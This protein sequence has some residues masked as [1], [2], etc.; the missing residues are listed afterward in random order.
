MKTALIL[1]AISG[2]YLLACSFEYPD[3]AFERCIDQNSHWV[4]TDTHVN[5][6][7]KK[8]EAITGFKSTF[9]TF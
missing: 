9:N 2:L 5:Q 6:V 1:M 4:I 3:E 8:C 7:I